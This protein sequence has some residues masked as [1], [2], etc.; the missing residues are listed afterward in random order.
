MTRY[1]SALVPVLRSETQA[2]LLAVTLLEPDRED[3]IAGIARRLEVSPGNLH[4]D[5]QRMV[6]AGIL[7]DRRVGRARLVRAARN[8]LADAVRDLIA[9][10]YGPKAVLEE[11][12]AGVSGVEEALIFGSWAARHSGTQGDPPHDIDLLVVGSPDRDEV[13]DRI[14]EVAADLPIPVQVV[15]RRDD[16]WRTDEDAFSQSLR[17]NSMVPLDLRRLQDGTS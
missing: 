7:M 4:A 5:V 2:R 1:S 8:P 16:S 9:V 13:H 12:L 15:F 14:A 11:A 10:A 3:T 17:E 6:E